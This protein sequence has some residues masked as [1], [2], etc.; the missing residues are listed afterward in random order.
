MLACALARRLRYPGFHNAVSSDQDSSLTMMYPRGF[1]QVSRSWHMRYPTL[2]SEPRP[3]GTPHTSTPPVDHL[4]RSTL[5]HSRA[6]PVSHQSFSFHHHL[7]CNMMHDSKYHIHNSHSPHRCVLKT[8]S[9]CPH[10]T[11][12]GLTTIH[13]T[14]TTSF[15]LMHSH[16]HAILIKLT[17]IIV[18]MTRFH[19]FIF[20]Y[21]F[22]WTFNHSFY[23]T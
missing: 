2:G 8:Q 7:V 21:T 17:L 14:H 18:I 9:L 5:R 4:W 11:V 23:F 13:H 20:T 15:M 10:D 12:N 19:H 1:G 16:H 22:E 6:S 3:L